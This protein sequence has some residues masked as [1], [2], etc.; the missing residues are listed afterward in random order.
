MPGKGTRPITDRTKEALF[1]I[2]GGW[3]IE[4]QVLD[5]FAGT[6]AVG[7]EALS[8]GAGRV[9]FVEKSRIATRVIGEN[10]RTTELA[11]RAFVMKKDAFNFLRHH[12]STPYDLIY[13]APPQYKEMW[14]KAIKVIDQTLIDWLQPDGLV[15]AQIHPIEFEDVPL[16]NLQLYDKRQYGSTLLCF[17]DQFE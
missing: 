9:T 2:L 1:N 11:E 13:V 10:L 17:Y 14:S 15:I 6:G 3:I 12:P 4:A 16:Q 7:I 5:L 8:R